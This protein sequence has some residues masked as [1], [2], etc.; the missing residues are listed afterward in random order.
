MTEIP[1]GGRCSIEEPQVRAVLDRLHKEA[2]AQ[3][4]AAAR[5]FLAFEL[6]RRHSVET[7][8]TRLRSLYLS[9]PPASGRFAYLVARS[10]QAHR[11][12]EF[13]TSFG[14]STTYLAAAVRDNGGGRVIGSEFVPEKAETAWVNLREAGLGEFVEI[15]IGDAQV[16][17]TDPGGSVDMVLLDGKKEL[18]LPILIGL[19]SHIRTGGVVLA[20][21]IYIFRKTLRS[22]VAYMRDA[23]HG[24]Q[25]I[26]LRLGTGL[27]HSVRL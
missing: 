3:K 16:T 24:F 8:A 4:W 26:T 21:N 13:G 17:L 5:T 14:V 23:A 2:D 12:V 27:E 7:E 18:Y 20:D 25:S 6:G 22:Y 19:A 9:L 11:I 1:G 10:I 15:R